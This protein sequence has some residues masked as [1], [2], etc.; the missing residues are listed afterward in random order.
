MFQKE[1]SPSPAANLQTLC[2]AFRGASDRKYRNATDSA[3]QRS[4]PADR[5][6]DLVKLQGSSKSSS[7]MWPVWLLL[8]IYNS[9]ITDSSLRFV[10]TST[11]LY[12]MKFIRC[13]SKESHH[14][15]VCD[16]KQRCIHMSRM[17][18][19][20]LWSRCKISHVCL[21]IFLSFCLNVVVGT[22]E[23]LI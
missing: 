21:Q 2:S 6:Q 20:C 3:G 9:A 12:D 18:F 1:I 8:R 11:D 13:N 19:E 23:L 14:S 10:L 5:M 17:K 15:F 22:Q 16:F 7:L 4:H